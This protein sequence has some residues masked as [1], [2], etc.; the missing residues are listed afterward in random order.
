MQRHV[1]HHELNINIY[2]GNVF[3]IKGTKHS[4]LWILIPTPHVQ[5]VLWLNPQHM[6]PSPLQK[7]ASTAY[8][9]IYLFNLLQK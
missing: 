7:Q 2:N 9:L 5:D 8:R 6:R 3:I 4:E 1:A